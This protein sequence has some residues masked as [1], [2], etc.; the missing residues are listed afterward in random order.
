MKFEYDIAISFASENRQI[1][2]Q[3]AKKL[4][5]YGIKVFYDEFKISKLFGTNLYK[6]LTEVYS[7]KSHYCLM[8][9]S[10][11]YIKKKWTRIEL[12]IA[13]A[14]QLND[15]HDYILPVRLDDT[16]V[17]GLSENTLYL[18]LRNI[19]VDK[20]AHIIIQKVNSIDELGDDW[21]CWIIV[22]QAHSSTNVEDVYNA[23]IE[24]FNKSTSVFPLRIDYS[25]F[26][27]RYSDK[28]EDFEDVKVVALICKLK[29]SKFISDS[30]WDVL[31]EFNTECYAGNNPNVI[32]QYNQNVI[33]KIKSV[34]ISPPEID[35]TKGMPKY[36]V[37]I[38]LGE[39]SKKETL[40]ES[41]MAPNIISV[42]GI[43]DNSPRMEDEYWY[44][45]FKDCVYFI[46]IKGGHVFTVNIDRN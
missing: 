25:I 12:K 45:N 18:D 10:K 44:Y 6:K 35:I 19:T 8:I 33:S 26:R 27:H 14:R 4:T 46:E 11:S 20:L 22:A 5:K 28:I 34:W 38:L 39:P 16:E 24:H 2:N 30:F 43:S 17:P 23:F 13:L 29:D 1:A 42:A 37:L 15:I 21:N 7:K 36:K 3:I 31:D 32:K 41:L 9:I 40:R